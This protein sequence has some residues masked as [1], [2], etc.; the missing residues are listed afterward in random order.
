MCSCNDSLISLILIMMFVSYFPSSTYVSH[1]NFLSKDL[2]LVA[3][4]YYK[5]SFKDFCTKIEE[6]KT[7]KNIVRLSQSSISK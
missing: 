3:I 2:W 7:K 1:A 6:K 4:G 5:N